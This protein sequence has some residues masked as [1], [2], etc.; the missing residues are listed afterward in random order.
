MSEKQI[1]YWVI[2]RGSP[3]EYLEDMRFKIPEWTNNIQCAMRGTRQAIETVLVQHNLAVT[4]DAR[5]CEHIDIVE[6]K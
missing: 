6:A 3:A 5:I 1:S 2:E 4:H